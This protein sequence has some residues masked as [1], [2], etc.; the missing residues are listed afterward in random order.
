MARQTDYALILMDIQLPTMSG[1][2]AALSA[3]SARR[4]G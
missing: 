2:D 3:V 1:I 4:S